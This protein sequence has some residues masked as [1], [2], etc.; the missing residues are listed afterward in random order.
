MNLGKK[1]LLASRVLKVGKGRIVFAKSRL[2]EIKE[3]ITK[4]DIR[5][6]HKDGAIRVKEIKGR[7]K[8]KKKPTRKSTGNIRKKVKTRKRDY[9]KLT[10][11]LRN[12][13]LDLR[14]QEKI[15]KQQEDE[16][17]KRIRNKAF[18]SKAHLKEF[19]G[20]LKKWD[21]TK[22]DEGSIKQII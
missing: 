3:A 9:A 1:K 6:L 16:M 5:D 15:S 13:L 21:Y 10:K 12:Y 2:D 18:R 14:N 7:K 8:N 22:E 11:K 19:I 17:R 4:Q 20:G